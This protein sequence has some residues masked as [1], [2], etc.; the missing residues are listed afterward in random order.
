MVSVAVATHI[1]NLSGEVGRVAIRML[2][3]LVH[4]EFTAI[5]L[6]DVILHVDH[7]AVHLVGS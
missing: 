4:V 5:F 6:D 2:S 1:T 7:T 3:E